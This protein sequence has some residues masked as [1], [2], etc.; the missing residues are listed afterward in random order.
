M[1]NAFL[2]AIWRW[3][4][5]D[6]GG[7][8]MT[9]PAT[10]Q[11]SRPPALKVRQKMLTA[12]GDSYALIRQVVG[13]RCRHIIYDRPLLLRLLGGKTIELL[14]YDEKGFNVYR[15]GYPVVDR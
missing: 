7:T 12:L 10:G 11:A 2:E 3:D 14:V 15:Q 8:R 13:H 1:S 5:R 6:K 4:H 9:T